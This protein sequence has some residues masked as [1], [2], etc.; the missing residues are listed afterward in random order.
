MPYPDISKG[1]I[2]NQ[3]SCYRHT[4]AVMEFKQAAPG[5]R[6]LPGHIFQA[7]FSGDGEK[8]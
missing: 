5:A 8:R 7:V 6:L 3:A 1:R 4:P 2:F